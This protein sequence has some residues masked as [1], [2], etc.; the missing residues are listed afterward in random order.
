MTILS[1]IVITAACFF[2]AVLNLAVENRFRN[3]IMGAFTCIAVSV[4]IA[5][6]GYGF[7]SVFG[8]S[9][10][11]VLRALLAVCR[12]FGGVNDLSAIQAAPLFAHEGILSVFWL[13]HFMAFYVTASAAIATVGGRMLRYIRVTRLRRGTLLIIYGANRDSVEY[14]V[15]Q[16]AGMHRSVV[17]I[18]QGC[19]AALEAAI[20]AAGAVLDKGG[21]QQIDRAFLRRMGVRS[22][23]RRIEVAAL[24]EDGVKN[25]VFARAFLAAAESA[26]VHAVQIALLIRAVQEEHA[27]SL[28]CSQSAY[29]YGSV[30]AFDEYELAA[31]LMMHVLAPC[32]T[33]AFDDSARA[34]EDF[35]ALIIGFGRMGRAVLEQLVMNG[36]FCGSSFRVDI[37]DAHAQRGIL[38]DHE[39]LRQYD[40]RFHEAGGKSEALYEFLKERRY[41]IRYIVLCTGEAKENRELA[42]DLKR[43]FGACGEVPAMVQ[44]TRQGLIFSDADEHDLRYQSLYDSDALDLEHIDAMAMAINHV[45]CRASGRT[46]FENWMH[47]DYFS[48]MSSR[49]SADF[50]PAVLRAAGT[51]REQVEAGNWSPKADV[52]ENLAITEH[53]RW[54][55]FHYVMGFH[56]MSEAEYEQRAAQY[57]ADI[58]ASGVSSLRIGKNMLERTHACLVPWEE[59]DA[60]SARENAIT[61]GQ[62]DYKAMDRNN[63]LALPE[64][65]KAHREMERG[66]KGGQT[67]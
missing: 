3:H 37:F 54:C 28:V 42:L 29:G 20:N 65:L 53:L 36:Q 49:A 16:I 1:I 50:Y 44:C 52:L 23:G 18:D 8:A 64:I 34:K 40:I 9:P 51:T 61:G 45:Y 43:W 2:A 48:R 60:L 15:R 57:R 11:A 13:I 62:V 59:L 35:S 17:F 24:H 22:G 7:A 19:D 56:R 21:V 32:E 33:I 67:A 39:L 6:Y 12:M 58:Q 31:R 55:A 41:A 27:G 26:G 66:N 4:G 14:A 46:A 63:V 30:L 5:I 47:C 38:H 10:V 25:I